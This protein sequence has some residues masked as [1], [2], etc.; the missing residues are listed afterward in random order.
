[1]LLFTL[2]GNEKLMEDGKEER[3]KREREK[4]LLLNT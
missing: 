2:E 4:V 1:L 3:S